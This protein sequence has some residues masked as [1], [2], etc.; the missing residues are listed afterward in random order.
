MKGSLIRIVCCSSILFGAFPAVAQVP[1]APAPATKTA[2]QPTKSLEMLDVGI[3]PRQELR[4]NPAVN[5]KQTL[6]MKIASELGMMMDGKSLQE[7]KSKV[8]MKMDLAVKKIDPNGDINYDYIYTSVDILPDPSM[9]A[10]TIKFIK[11][12]MATVVGTKGSVVMD[13]TGQIKSQTLV[14]SKNIDP[15]IQKSIE[16]SNKQMESF[17]IPLPTTKVGKGARWKVAQISKVDNLRIDQTVTY[18][19]IEINDRQVTIESNIQQSAPPQSMFD[20]LVKLNY[21]TSTGSGR[22][23]FQFGSILPIVGS[24][25]F[26]TKN[27]VETTPDKDRTAIKVDTNMKLEMNMTSP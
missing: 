1:P 21:M 4:F 6:T 2:P 3:E 12:K 14:V 16:S 15:T 10:D 5:S 25:T 9:S 20:G 11:E 22:S 24:L 7:S 17:S 27:Q 8:E 18:K 13:R 26:N 23:T 19:V